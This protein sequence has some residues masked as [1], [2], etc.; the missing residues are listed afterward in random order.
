M[1]NLTQAKK[2]GVTYNIKDEI[3][4]E[5]IDQLKLYAITTEGTVA[6]SYTNV[7][8]FPINTVIGVPN[9]TVTAGTLSN[10]PSDIH[11]GGIVITSTYNKNATSLTGRIQICFF[12]TKSIYAWRVGYA[13]AYLEWNYVGEPVVKTYT[14]KAS[15]GNFTTVAGAMNFITN[16]TNMPLWNEHYRAEIVIDPGTYSLNDVLTLYD[17][18]ST[19]YRYGFFIP[20]YC[21]IRGA[22]KKNTVLTFTPSYTDTS[23]E[24]LVSLSA[25]NMPYESTLKDLSLI[26][27]N[28]RYCVHSE[29][30]FPGYSD[31]TNPISS[32]LVN[33]CLITVENVYMEHKGI[34]S[35]YTPSYA[36][37]A[38]WGSGSYDASDQKFINCDFVSSQYCAWLNHN[39]IGLTKPSHFYFENCTFTNQS[40]LIQ[41]SLTTGRFASMMFISW[42]DDDIV[43]PV[44]M[45]N[46]YANRFVYLSVR[47]T[48]PASLTSKNNYYITA[49]N[50]IFIAEYNVNNAYQTDNYLTANCDVLMAEQAITNAYRPVSYNDACVAH[51]YISS[52][53]YH[54]IALHLADSGKPVKVQ[55][56]GKIMLARCGITGYAAGTMLGYSNG[57]W[58]V[59]TS[60]PIIHVLT[61]AIGE[62]V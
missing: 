33:N 37:P 50:D 44:T 13:G 52:D 31:G 17:R 47:N 42:A 14:V 22:G 40:E 53:P 4:R 6:S 45:N 59:D 25:F 61:T 43:L 41:G 20:P 32:A 18:D 24:R 35:Q 7:D 58:V 62:V 54:G 27:K 16:P 21:T 36:A 55:K 46:C 49:N 12:Y 60:H 23:D 56:R 1:P 3:A 10:F 30:N 11:E 9:E 8:D 38:C 19:W 57:A 51:G 5:D 2:G 39:R 28:C 26:V 29:N 48:E 15:G 34:E